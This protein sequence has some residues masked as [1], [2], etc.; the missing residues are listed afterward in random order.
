MLFSANHC[1]QKINMK[2]QWSNIIELKTKFGNNFNWFR[3]NKILTCCCHIN[4][5]GCGG[6]DPQFEHPE[7]RHTC[8]KWLDKGVLL[9]ATMEKSRN[10]SNIKQ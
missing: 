6:M 7:T 1:E 5:R 9:Q 3:T 4:W 10:K 8:I 2:M